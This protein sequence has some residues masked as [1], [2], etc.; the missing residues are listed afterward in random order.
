MMLWSFLVSLF[1]SLTFAAGNSIDC[2]ETLE[3][4][5]LM[6]RK[7]SYGNTAYSGG[8]FY[9]SASVYDC[10]NVNYE[11]KYN[12]QA[13]IISGPASFDSNVYQQC[14]IITYIN[15]H[16]NYYHHI[17]LYYNTTSDDVA[18]FSE[19]MLLIQT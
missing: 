14:T 4:P 11:W 13:C 10:Y 18:N 2:N 12:L 16:N 6:I 7:I 19:A 5:Y 8:P 1:T 17:T 15:H 9:I 3:C